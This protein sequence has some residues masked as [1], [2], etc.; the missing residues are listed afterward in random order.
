ML[1]TSRIEMERGREAWVAGGESPLWGDITTKTPW[2]SMN[3]LLREAT[4]EPFQD[5]GVATLRLERG[6]WTGIRVI[7]VNLRYYGSTMD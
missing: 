6:W 5:I 4:I 1:S 2:L 3:L 7:T